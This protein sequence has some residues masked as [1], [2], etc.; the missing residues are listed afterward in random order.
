[1]PELTVFGL[2]WFKVKTPFQQMQEKAEKAKLKI[3]KS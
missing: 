1:M 2:A 3:R